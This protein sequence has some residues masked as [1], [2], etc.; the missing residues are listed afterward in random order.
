VNRSKVLITGANG[1][2]G[3][4][5][6][7]YLVSAGLSVNCAMRTDT[8]L[9]DKIDKKILIP[10]IYGRTDWTE[11]LS[12]REVV[13]HLAARVHVMNDTSVDPLAEF[14]KVN[15]DGTLNLA[16]QA[17][18]AGV[19]RFIFISSVKVN[20]E[21][22]EAGKPFTEEVAANPQDAYG[23]SKLEAEQGLLKIAQETGMEVVI[24][25]PPLV[26]GA[27]VKANFASMM[28]AVK[29]GVPLPLGAIHNKRSFV[30]VGNLVSMIMRCIDHPAAANQVFLVSDGHDLSTTELLR[31]CAVALRVKAR[32][33]PVP[34]KFIEVCANLLGK[35]AVAQRLC[36]NLQLDITK[37]STMLGW[38][39]PFS[40]ADGLQVTAIDL[41]NTDK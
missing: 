41:L 11:A 6:T 4:Y 39:P 29:R 14:R 30:Y 1:F 7:H 27:G 23:I 38:T 21:H 28:R 15:V 3:R 12:G 31:C 33:L 37:A 32:L 40:V 22:T 25:R 8:V 35:R 9:D 13:I 16:R 10:S 18:S 5:L 19:K 17:A 34:Q 20:G 26:Y 24:I 36:G 2:V